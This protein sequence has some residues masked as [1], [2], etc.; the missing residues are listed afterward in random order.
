MIKHHQWLTPDIGHTKLQE[1]LTALMALQRIAGN[2]WNTFK[3]LL[4]KAFPRYR[5][6]LSFDFENIDNFQIKD[7][8]LPQ[9][10][11]NRN[12]KGLLKYH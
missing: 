9:T 12:L 4:D 8:D 6:T 10:H 2:N 11:F 7:N 1:H 3:R 5:H